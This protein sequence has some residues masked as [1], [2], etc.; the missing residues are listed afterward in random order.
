MYNL[1]FV[2]FFLFCGVEMAVY[3]IRELIPKTIVEYKKGLKK[4]FTN[5]QSIEIPPVHFLSPL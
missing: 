3:F 5:F 1:K 4:D 2:N